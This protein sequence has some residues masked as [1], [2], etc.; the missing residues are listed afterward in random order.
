M[1]GWVG[2]LQHVECITAVQT[3]SDESCMATRWRQMFMQKVNLAK[4]C[5][6]LLH[7]QMFGTHQS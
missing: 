7:L 2:V 1:C 6:W 3:V 4:E 5:S